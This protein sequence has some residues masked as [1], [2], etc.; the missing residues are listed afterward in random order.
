MLEAAPA[1]AE[2]ERAQR[3]LLGSHAIEQQRA[4]A[5]ATHISLD[6]LYGL[7]PADDRSYPNRIRAVTRDDVL[8]VAQRIFTLSRPTIATI[9]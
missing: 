6:A 4:S 9:V 2:L 7:G 3:Y 1:A 8:R 5:R